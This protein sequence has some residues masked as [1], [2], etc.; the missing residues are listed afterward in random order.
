M[1]FFLP[2]RDLGPDEWGA[3]ASAFTSQ[4]LDTWFQGARQPGAPLPR[5]PATDS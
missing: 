2:P 1:M 3:E 4:M 5:P